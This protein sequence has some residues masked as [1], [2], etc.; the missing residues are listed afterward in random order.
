ML[1]LKKCLSKLSYNFGLVVHGLTAALSLD[2][3]SVMVSFLWVIIIKISHR[4]SQSCRTM[5]PLVLLEEKENPFISH[6]SWVNGTKKRQELTPDE[7]II[8]HEWHVCQSRG[9]RAAKSHAWPTRGTKMGRGSERDFQNPSLPL[10][11]GYL[12]P[13]FNVS[14][15]IFPSLSRLHS[16]PPQSNWFRSTSWGGYGVGMWA[17]CFHLSVNF[18]QGKINK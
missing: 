2:V 9:L 14:V 3:P 10:S 11:L 4:L 17:F 12:P 6:I 16:P 1:T 5:Q 13:P 8:H 18:W 15:P 7:L